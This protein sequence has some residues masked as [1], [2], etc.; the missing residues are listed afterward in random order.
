MNQI[1]KN[2]S[3]CKIIH[4]KEN[5]GIAFAL[6]QGFINAKNEGFKWVVTFDQ[7]SLPFPDIIETLSLTYNSYFRKDN[8]GAIGINYTHENNSRVKS[9]LSGYLVQEYLITSGCLIPTNTFNKIGPFPEH[10]FIDNVDLE[11]SLRIR[12]S[13][14]ILLITKKIGMYHKAGNP[15]IKKISPKK[16]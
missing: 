1:E 10:Y 14:K 11:Y 3:C 16:Y 12:K 8:I 6:N 9:D 15:K 5:K 2:Y 7:D 13:G 4:N